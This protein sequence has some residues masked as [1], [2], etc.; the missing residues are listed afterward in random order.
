[1]Q[2]IFKDPVLLHFWLT[3]TKGDNNWKLSLPTWRGHLS[4]EVSYNLYLGMI[5]FQKQ[6]LPSPRRCH[7]KAFH[8]VG[9][10]VWIYCGWNTRIGG[11]SWFRISIKFHTMRKIDLPHPVECRQVNKENFYILPIINKPKI[12]ILLWSIL[13]RS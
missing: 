2:I 6:P 7:F 3:W 12:V 10:F 9:N 11:C 13:I 5:I 1:M 8:G 4:N